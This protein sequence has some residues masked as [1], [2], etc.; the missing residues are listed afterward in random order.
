MLLD[1]IPNLIDLQR[2]LEHLAVMEPP[3]AKKELV[4]E[5][6]IHSLLMYNKL[7]NIQ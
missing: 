1:Q 2:Y 5:Q 7:L 6:V 3:I 4:L